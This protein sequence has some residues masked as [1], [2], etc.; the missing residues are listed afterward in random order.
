MSDMIQS[1]LGDEWEMAV[2]GGHREIEFQLGD[3]HFIGRFDPISESWLDRQFPVAIGHHQKIEMG[4]S[5]S[6]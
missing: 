2:F 5:K 4:K 6:C 3:K 1:E